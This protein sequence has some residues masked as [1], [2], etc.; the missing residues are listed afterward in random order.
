MEYWIDIFI[1]LY[2]Y[3]DYY[4]YMKDIPIGQFYSTTFV[5]KYFQSITIFAKDLEIFL[6]NKQKNSKEYHHS[7]DPNTVPREN[8][9]DISINSEGPRVPLHELFGMFKECAVQG[10]RGITPPPLPLPLPSTMYYSHVLNLEKN[11]LYRIGDLTEK[12]QQAACIAEYNIPFPDRYIFCLA[13]VSIENE[14]LRSILSIPIF[15][16]PSFTPSSLLSSSHHH[17]PLDAYRNIAHQFSKSQKVS[18]PSKYVS[19]LKSAK[20]PED[21]LN[22]ETSHQVSLPLSF[23]LLVPLLSLSLSHDLSL[24]L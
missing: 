11:T 13:P 12:Q 8:P 18:L 10:T 7:I 23:S 15:L 4:N 21:L 2:G 1:S 20:T 6:Y 22:L 3:E 9:I 24:D 19:L 14:K 16:T 5:L 17:L